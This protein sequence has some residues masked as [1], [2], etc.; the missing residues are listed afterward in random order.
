MT[1]TTVLASFIYFLSSVGIIS[2][3]RLIQIPS[4]MHK[5]RLSCHESHVERDIK[6]RQVASHSNTDSWS[7]SIY[8]KKNVSEHILCIRPQV[9]CWG[10]TRISPVLGS[11]R[12][13]AR[14]QLSPV[15]VFLLPDPLRSVASP[16]S[17]ILFLPQHPLSPNPKPTKSLSSAHLIQPMLSRITQDSAPPHPHLLSDSP[18]LLL[19]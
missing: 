11:C 1:E 12:S 8:M 7:N 6:H 19:P 15:E 2:K 9:G 18:S 5:E 10:Y 3:G 14:Y 4:Y 16:P 13:S 17:Y